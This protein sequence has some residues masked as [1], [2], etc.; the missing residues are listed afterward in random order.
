MNLN[1][2]ST[3]HRYDNGAWNSKKSIEGS[4]KEEWKKNYRCPPINFSEIAEEDSVNASSR[5]ASPYNK[6]TFEPN[7]ITGRST[8]N[9]H[10]K[11]KVDFSNF[12]PSTADILATSFA[13]D[14]REMCSKMNISSIGGSTAGI[15]HSPKQLMDISGTF[16]FSKNASLPGEKFVPSDEVSCFW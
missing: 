4:R 2:H 6:H 10:Q 11:S 15:V 5:T 14:I 16:S 13:D 12:S 7:E 3:D 9:T 8:T 1:Q